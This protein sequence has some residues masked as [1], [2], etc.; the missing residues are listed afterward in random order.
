M[1]SIRNAMKR[2]IDKCDVCIDGNVISKELLVKTLSGFISSTIEDKRH[3]VGIILHTGSICF[4]A[5]LLAYAAISNILYNET[6]ATDLIHSLHI[7]D[8][9]LCYNGSRGKTKP[10]KWVFEGFVN[11]TDETPQEIP[12]T[13]VVLQN[14]KKGRNYLPEGSWIKI[15][16]YYGASKSMDS[17]GLRQEDGKRYDFFKSVLEMQD[18]EIPRTIDTSTIVVMSR[19]EANILV[20]SLSFRFGKTDIK[21]TDL[22]PVSYYTESN[23][24][25]QY[26]INPSKNEPVIKLTGKVSVARNLLLRRGGNRHIGLIVLGEDMYRRGESEL[27]E[28]LDRQ[29]IQYVYLC[30][31]LDSEV[32]ANLIAN[33]EEANLFACT[34]DFLLSNSRPPIV[35]NPYTEQ[36]DARDRGNH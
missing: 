36:M 22:V 5:I 29:S 10:S 11:S 2:I 8:V 7:G 9:V 30:M 31:H 6:N 27:P 20:G 35:C 26:G 17:R 34:K 1:D 24:E 16:P 28:L 15:V 25:Y 14:E 18:A 13:Y 4:D 12:G 33:Y 3:N 21:L 32:S 23:Q 19:E